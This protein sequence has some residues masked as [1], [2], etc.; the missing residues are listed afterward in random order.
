MDMKWKLNPCKSRVPKHKTDQANIALIV[1]TIILSV[2]RHVLIQQPGI[3]CVIGHHQF[4]PVCFNHPPNMI[5][6]KLK[7]EAY[8]K[9]PGTAFVLVS[10]ANETLVRIDVL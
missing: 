1:P 3:N 7:F 8:T 9:L 6:G 2:I 10:P 4:F 5:A